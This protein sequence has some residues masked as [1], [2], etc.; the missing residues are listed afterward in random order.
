[1]RWLYFTRLQRTSKDMWFIFL[2]ERD[3]RP[4]KFTGNAVHKGKVNRFEKWEVVVSLSHSKS[5]VNRAVF[6]LLNLRKR[7]IPVRQTIL[8]RYRLQL[9]YLIRTSPSRHT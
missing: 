6:S 4:S 8:I 7:T 5:A 2:G 1:M 3:E 9:Q